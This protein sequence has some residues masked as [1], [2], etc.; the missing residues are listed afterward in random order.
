[1][2]K[3]IAVEL[4]DG[5]WIYLKCPSNYDNDQIASLVI[6]YILKYGMS[7]HDIIQIIV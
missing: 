2:E 5:N 7:T 3:E 4:K 6:E 1:M